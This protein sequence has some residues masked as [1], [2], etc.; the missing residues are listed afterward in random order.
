[1]KTKDIKKEWKVAGYKIIIVDDDV[2]DTAPRGDVQAVTVFSVGKYV[3]CD[4]LEREYEKRGL[5]PANLDSLF[6]IAGQHD[7]IA[8]QWKGSDG[9]YCC[10]A[11]DDWDD[12]R[13]VG[14]LRSARAWSDCW[15]FAGVPEVSS[16]LSPSE[17]PS[18]TLSLEVLINGV[19]YAPVV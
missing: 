15:S 16:A 11:F 5:V 10:A 9:K 17:K 4:E 13:R 2:L 1:M 19:K 3:T 18:D 14:V 6:A 8:T 12:G 7:F